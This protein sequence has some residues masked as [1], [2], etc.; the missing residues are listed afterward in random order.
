MELRRLFI[1]PYRISV[2][3]TRTGDIYALFRLGAQKIGCNLSSTIFHKD[4][5]PF[6]E[7]RKS[8]YEKLLRKELKLKKVMNL[9]CFGNCWKKI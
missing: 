2:R 4:K 3:K 6:V 7:S 8:G 9:M 5:L 1:K